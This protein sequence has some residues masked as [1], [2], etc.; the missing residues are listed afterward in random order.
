MNMPGTNGRMMMRRWKFG[1]LKWD[2]DGPVHGRV[3]IRIRVACRLL[4]TTCVPAL[5]DRN[6]RQVQE[7]DDVLVPARP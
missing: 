4:L 1:P 3:P 6:D 5:G 2:G 7:Q